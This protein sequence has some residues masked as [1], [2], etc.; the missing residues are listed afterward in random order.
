MGP[1]ADGSASSNHW[2]LRN[3][4]AS[5]AINLS[6][7]AKRRNVARR[8]NS[9]CDIDLQDAQLPAHRLQMAWQAGKDPSP[10]L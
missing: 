8:P 10:P 5:A 7:V 1:Q 9:L 3:V 4:L 6:N 2:K